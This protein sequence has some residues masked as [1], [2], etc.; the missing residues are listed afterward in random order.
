MADEGPN[1]FRSVEGLPV[2]AF[3]TELRTHTFVE[4]NDAAAAV[5]GSPTEELLGADVLDHIEPS[6]RERVRTAYA[7][8]ADKVVDGYQVLRR[9][10]TPD[11]RVV[12][13][14]VW[15][16][17]VEVADKLYGLWILSPAQGST[18]DIEALVL[19]SPP[20]VLAMTDHD[21]QIE[22][23][24]ADADLLGAKGAEFRGFPL[25]GLVH[26]SAV[27]DFLV[28]A[29]QASNDQL[30]VTVLTRLRSGP[31]QWSN[32]HCLI[33]PICQHSPPR[34][35][36]VISMSPS[37]SVGAGSKDG[38]DKQVR[39]CAVE[40]RGARALSV[41]PALTRLPAG[42]ELSARQSEIVA[43][44]VSGERVPD[45]ARSMSLSA[46]TVRNH[47][48]AI[49]RKVGVHSQ[50]ELLAALLRSVAPQDE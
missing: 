21:W 5:F 27:S 13:V 19:G 33:V 30:A 8:L 40:A 43:R 49:Y 20:V 42:A 15:G 24:S 34:L 10:V 37:V 39:S 14:N 11:G 45:F 31:G 18:T 38:F 47:L 16:R 3:L 25:L 1:V 35:G 9:V 12:A 2:A 4:L 26:P 32:R 23:M 50:T 17:R 41:L 44:L 7:A 36:V 6:D 22:Y 48:S 46:A 28:A 29:S